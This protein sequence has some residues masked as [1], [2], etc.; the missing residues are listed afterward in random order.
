MFEFLISNQYYAHR[1]GAFAL[2]KVAGN[3]LRMETDEV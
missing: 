3:L 1:L 2:D